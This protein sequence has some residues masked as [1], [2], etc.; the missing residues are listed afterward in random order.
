MTR[1]TFALTFLALF[2]LASG[3]VAQTSPPPAR[4]DGKPGSARWTADTLAAVADHGWMLVN[5]VPDDIA[6]YCPSYPRADQQQRAAFWM[7]LLSALTP[8][9]SNYNPRTTYTERFNDNQG[10]PVISRGLLQISIESANGYGCGITDAQ[11]LH[12]PQVNLSCGVRIIQRL[13]TR[14][15]V[16]AS[17]AEPW[18]GA[19]AYW[20]P[21]RKPAKRADIAGWTKRQPYCR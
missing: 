10:R 12:D 6:A 4:W 19:A 16:I 20:S 3:A 21:F 13:V 9:E 7:G 1:K 17:T 2:A 11:Q 8:H 14:H 5:S 15:G 18:R